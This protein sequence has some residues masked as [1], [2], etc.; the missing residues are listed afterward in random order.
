MPFFCSPC[1]GADP[2]SAPES[3]AIICRKCDATFASPAEAEAHG[4][5][6]FLNTSLGVY[7]IKGG[8]GLAAK[9]AGARKQVHAAS[10]RQSHLR[11]YIRDSQQE[12]T[13]ASFGSEQSPPSGLLTQDSD[14][15]NSDRPVPPPSTFGSSKTNKSTP[16][17]KIQP[18]AT[19][20]NVRINTAALDQDP[21]EQI[22]SVRLPTKAPSSPGGQKYLQSL[23]QTLRDNREHGGRYKSKM[24]QQ[25]NEHSTKRDD[26]ISVH[27]NQSPLGSRYA[28]NVIGGADKFRAS[29]M[30][31]DSSRKALGSTRTSPLTARTQ[32]VELGGASGSSDAHAVRF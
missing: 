3:I 23:Q 24:R 9:S 12:L 28:N 17:R 31:T 11:S 5:N 13:Q 27:G 29:P 22:S 1:A 21:Q 7:G 26:H 25:L 30:R 18:S 8:A 15:Q 16:A 19:G 6:C 20:P 4:S 14:Q 2:S 32:A 10:R